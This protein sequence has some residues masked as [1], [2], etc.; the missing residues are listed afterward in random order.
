MPEI[1]R[2]KDQDPPI[3]RFCLLPED[4]EIKAVDEKSRKMVHKISTEAID[5]YRDI[6]RADGGEYKNYKKNPVVLYGHD[7][8]TKKPLPIIGKNAGF[9]AE[10]KKL[11]ATTE[12]WK[13]DDPISQDLK[14]LVG[15]LWFMNQKKIMG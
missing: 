7:Y 6:I 3:L 12:F 11:W 5:R 1:K 4:V 13:D 8:Y 15:D 10:K 2:T 14:D 9:E